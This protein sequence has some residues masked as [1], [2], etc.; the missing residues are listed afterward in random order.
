MATEKSDNFIVFHINGSPEKDLI[1]TAVIKAL[2]KTKPNKKIIVVTHFPEIWLHNPNVYRVYKHGAAPYFYEDC[3]KDK[4]TEIYA[5]DPYLTSDYIYKKKPVAEIWCDM[6]GIPYKNEQPSLHFTQREEEVAWRLTQTQKPVL[7]IQGNETFPHIPNLQFNWTKDLPID[8][9]Q[10]IA[11]IARNKGYDVVQVRNQ[12]QPPIAGAVT[13][14][15]SLRLA[16]ASLK[17]IKKCLFIDSFFQHAAAAVGKEAVVSWLSAPSKNGYKIHR[18]IQADI[19]DNIKDRLEEYSQSFDIKGEHLN[20]P[21]I[22][23]D[24]Y[25]LDKILEALDL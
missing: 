10:Q 13:L 7:L 18:N 6:I 5:F 16:L 12:N 20:R 15:L 25:S 21:V 14:N 4:G 9:L 22:L 23:E 24:V 19:T 1:G 2:H 8:L 11:N 17:N 3:V